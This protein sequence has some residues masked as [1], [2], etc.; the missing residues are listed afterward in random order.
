[1]KAR[2]NSKITQPENVKKSK[3]FPMKTGSV[4]TS[5]LAHLS[6]RLKGELIVYRSIRRASVKNIF[7]LEYLRNQWADRNQILSEASLG[8]GLIALQGRR[9]R[10]G[11]RRTTF[12]AEYVIRR[13]AFY[14]PNFEKVGSILVSACAFVRPFV[15]S[16]QNSS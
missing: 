11:A 8:G 12:L 1:M 16:K 4:T 15:R 7:K 2:I 13:F 3:I 14:A 5:F 9:R 6:Q 10:S